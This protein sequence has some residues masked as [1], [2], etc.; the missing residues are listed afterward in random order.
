MFKE[1]NRN[2]QKGENKMTNQCDG[3]N[4]GK[5]IERGNLHRM[6]DGLYPDFMSCQKDRYKPTEPQEVFTR[7]EIYEWLDKFM[8]NEVKISFCNE[9]YKQRLLW[10]VETYLTKKKEDKL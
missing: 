9:D 6:S 1:I 8:T 4:A 7:E 3:C 10:Y 5:P 2:N